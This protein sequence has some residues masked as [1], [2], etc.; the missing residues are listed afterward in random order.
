MKLGI[1]AALWVSLSAPGL[2]A[3]LWSA[4]PGPDA[5]STWLAV[6]GSVV[7]TVTWDGR[8]VALQ[9]ETGKV[10]WR[11]PPAAGT[12][13]AA[14]GDLVATIAEGSARIEGRQVQSGKV[15][16]S[17]DLGAA[18]TSLAS[19][20]RH[21]VF[22]VTHRAATPEG[23]T[24]VA[25]ALAPE[26]GEPLWISPV[27]GDLVAGLHDY[28][29]VLAPTADMA[30]GRLQALHAASGEPALTQ[31]LLLPVRRVVGSAANTIVVT[32]GSRDA[33]ESV[34]VVQ[35][36][37]DGQARC[38]SASAFGPGDYVFSSAALSGGVLYVA[39]SHIM[40]HNLDDRP[41]GYVVAIDVSSGAELRRSE[42]GLSGAMIVVSGDKLVT[43][44]GGTGSKDRAVVLD[45]DT[46]GVVAQQP[47]GKAPGWLV[48]DGAR[49]F[50]STYDGHV[51]AI[52]IPGGS[53]E[54]RPLLAAVEPRS[55]ASGSA[56]PALQLAQAARQYSVH[57][58][59][60]KTSGQKTDGSVTALAFAGPE[61]E[62]LLIG[63]NDDKVRVVE[64]ATGKVVHTGKSLRKDVTSVAA[65]GGTVVVATYEGGPYAYDGPDSSGALGKLRQLP[66][67]LGE[68]LA[69][70]STCGS[71]GGTGLISSQEMVRFASGERVGQIPE[72]T[73]IDSRG[74]RYT[75]HGWVEVSADG[76]QYRA[77]RLQG[78]VPMP[79]SEWRQVP[80]LQGGGLTQAWLPTPQRAL[81][82]RCS[83]VK[84]GVWLLD[85]ETGAKAHELIF[86][87]TGAVWVA[88]V[89]SSLEVAP[90][91]AYLWFHRDGLEA[92]LVEL[93]S[94]S[95]HVMGA[96]P[97]TMAT[98]PSAAFSSSGRLL[99]V[100]MHPSPWMVTVFSLGGDSR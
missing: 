93:K 29:V 34:C 65:C 50:V 75:P 36:G 11:T 49:A 89:P 55:S 77:I 21:A 58:K 79:P 71:V 84:C 67:G 6:Q 30:V 40:A 96:I 33:E 68:S 3:P 14:S 99:A 12:Q 13:A 43:G 61:S 39:M 23:P 59:T 31:K 94:G 1:L 64:V 95:R 90:N 20:T 44:F 18:P 10:A 42:P 85:V 91:G 69:F 48:S 60:A 54:A 16:W 82:E 53:V 37:E 63:G 7:T 4:R 98:T 28:F 19:S 27:A 17:R 46:L 38:F 45:L 22:A 2:A 76:T 72:V 86:D 5:G 100:A 97:R 47:L 32:A 66:F 35:L 8:V 15:A 70:S 26:S 80:D 41:D 88:S 57:P 73:G 25:T 92:Q 56:A 83:G 62:W 74:F 81:V 51:E 87:T 24:L 9:A 52:S 78:D